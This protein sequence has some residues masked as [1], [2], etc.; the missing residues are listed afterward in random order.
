MSSVI[1]VGGGAAGMMAAVA[2][3]R[4]G[5]RVTLL[6]KNEKLGKKIYITGKGRCNFTNAC[7]VEQLFGAV[8]SNPKFLYSAIYGFDNSMTMEFF[9]EMGMP[10]KV[11]RGNRVFP[12]SDHSSDVTK[13]L[14]RA[15]D[16]AGVKV[17]LQTEVKDIRTHGEQVVGVEVK[18]RG[19]GGERRR[20]HTEVLPADAV[21][22]A[23]GGISYPTTGSTGDGYGWA[24]RLGHGLVD[25]RPALVPMAALEDYIPAMQGLSLRNVTLRIRDQR[26]RELYREFGE[27]L[28][29]HFGVSGP[30]V[31]TASSLVGKKLAAEGTLAASIDLKPA[32][33][34]KQLQ[35]RLLRE[36]SKAPNRH[37]GNVLREV[38]PAK[39]VPVAA[40]LSH[41]PEHQP[42]RE[43]TREQRNDLVKLL[44][45]FPF[46]LCGLRGF[47]EAIITQGGVSVRDVDPS[48]MESRKVGGLY[49]AG[50]V[51]DLD[52]L[53]G[54]FNLQ[55][56]WSTGFL[57]GSSVP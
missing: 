43:I 16:Q 53:T 30:L 54:G 45:G 8:V 4:R 11:E 47:S 39:M 33:E 6:E 5:H 2:A 23:T 41:I 35:E 25:T 51:L 44:K 13:A 15:M 55:I 9:R 34:E 49:F 1:V 22:V 7:D 28:F 18:R 36:F 37:F 3:G 50:E 40:E 12:G 52:A 10:W 26:G 27:M 48:T 57:A 56:A 46:T 24:K 14:E 31:L 17:L 29:T 20:E 42:V 38:L 19:P 32:L 21:I